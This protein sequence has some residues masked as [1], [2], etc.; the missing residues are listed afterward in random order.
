MFL[1]LIQGY[2]QTI[3]QN[4]NSAALSYEIRFRENGSFSLPKVKW[5]GKKTFTFQGCKL[6]ND[7]PTNI[8]SIAHN[9]SFKVAVKAHFLNLL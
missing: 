5:F 8:K 2:P 1:R 9:H 7:L 3:S 6:W 4:R